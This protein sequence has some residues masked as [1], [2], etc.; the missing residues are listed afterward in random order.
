MFGACLSESNK[1]DERTRAFERAAISLSRS[2]KSMKNC[3]IDGLYEFIKTL[4][5]GSKY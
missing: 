1:D 2:W 5:S 4:T 3:E